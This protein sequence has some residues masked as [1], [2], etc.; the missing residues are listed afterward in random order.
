MKR[1]ISLFIEKSVLE[2]RGNLIKQVLQHGSLPL[3][4]IFRRSK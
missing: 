2:L 1:A 4:M 3:L